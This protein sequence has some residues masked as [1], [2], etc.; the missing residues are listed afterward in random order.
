MSLLNRQIICSAEP[1][2]GLP[3]H[4]IGNV[5]VRSDDN[6]EHLYIDGAADGGSPIY[7]GITKSR[8]SQSNKLPIE[9]GDILGGLQVY[10]RVKAGDSL[11][12]CHEETPLHGSIMFRASTDTTDVLSTELLLAVN[13]RDGLQVKLVLDSHGHLNVSGNI[14]TG[15]LQITDEEV[16]ADQPVKFVKAIYEDV[17]YA[18]PLYSIR[19]KLS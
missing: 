8:G 18:I 11:G 15:E 9:P 4:I 13:S 3:K 14:K 12:Y 19:E 7:V 1:G 5:I 10:A 2:T 17:E 16:L 6:S